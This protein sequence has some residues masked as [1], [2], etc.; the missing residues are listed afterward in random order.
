[1]TLKDII[2]QTQTQRPPERTYMIICLDRA[3]KCLKCGMISYNEYDIK[4]KYC[5]HCHEYHDLDFK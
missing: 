1:M 2:E 3:I 4:H 5:G